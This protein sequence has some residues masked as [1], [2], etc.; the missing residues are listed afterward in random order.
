MKRIAILGST[1]SVGVQTLDVVKQH[2]QEF[3]VE[4]LTANR[5]IDL[6]VAQARQFLPN[7]VVVAD[8][9]LYVPLKDALKSLPIK[10]FAGSKA[11]AEIV[12]MPSIDIVVNALVGIVG[13]PPT[14]AAI[15]SQKNIALANKESLVVAG[16]LIKRLCL[17]KN[18]SII[19]IDS[20]HSAI[21]QC[22]AGEIAPIEKIIL[23]ASG[24]PFLD[25]PIEQ[26]TYVSKNEAL[27]HPQWTMGNK[28][29]IDSATMMNKG[30]EVIEARWLFD[31][32]PQQIEVVVHPQS[33]VHS[34]VQFA[35]GSLKAQMGVCD[36]KIPSAYALSQPN[37]LKLNTLR[38]DF[39]QNP[40]LTFFAPDLQKFPCLQLAYDAMRAGGVACCA[41]NAAN[42]AAVQA[43][44]EERISFVQ[45]ARIVAK[46]LESHIHIANPTLDN[47]WAT[48]SEVRV[49]AERFCKGE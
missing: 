37:R 15:D 29:T 49:Q 31:L 18:V 41:L 14:L 23:T 26:L 21:F 4:I 5:N 16:E 45:I 19:P 12:T 1:G 40:T 46:C 22:L 34:L 44:L 48:D 11:L 25:T 33:V 42:E 7:A 27:R 3:E 17:Q 35:D 30:F 10:V 13:L 2:P 36:M 9:S 43:F 20:E 47:Y 38:Y 39:L 6:L 28:I 8:E 32:A 24:G